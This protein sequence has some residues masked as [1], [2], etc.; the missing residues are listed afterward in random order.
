MKYQNNIREEELKNRIASVFF[1]KYD[2]TEI[3][4]DI[5]FSVK[6]KH[7]KNNIDFQDEYLL[8]A[9]AKKHRDEIPD[10]LAQLILTIGKARIFNTYLPPPF[11]GCFDC[12]KIAFI[13]YSDIQHIFYQNDFNWKVTPS[14]T[15]TKEFK[16]LTKQIRNIIDNNRA[17]VF[18]FSKDENDLRSFISENFV[19]GKI[20]TSKIRI[21][22]NNFI[23]VYNK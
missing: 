23:N 5:D 16:Q 18:Y 14:N 1:N 2:C 15:E 22:K 13:E 3:I 6:I 10:M 7:P 8:W 21:D 17:Y 20:D 11:I 4:K 12:E 19:V 9:E